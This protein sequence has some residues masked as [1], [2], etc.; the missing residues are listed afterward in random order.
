MR[1]EY[2]KSDGSINGAPNLLYGQGSKAWSF[3]LTP[4]Y[5]YKRLFAR[6]EFSFTKANNIVNG[7]GFGP[8]GTK[9][10]QARGLLEV[11]ILF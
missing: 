10:S 7:L 9:T 8:N 3:T 11:G 6:T 1:L 5:Q 4:T 2:I